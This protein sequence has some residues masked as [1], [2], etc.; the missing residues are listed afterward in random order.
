MFYVYLDALLPPLLQHTSH[1]SETHYFPL[2]PDATRPSP[3]LLHSHA[4]GPFVPRTTPSRGFKLRVYASGECF[5]SSLSLQIDWWGTLGRWG[6]RYAPA[7]ISWAVGIVALVLFDAWTE[8]DMSGMLIIRWLTPLPPSFFS[9][10]GPGSRRISYDARVDANCAR[11]SSAVFRSNILLVARRVPRV[12]LRTSSCGLLAGKRRGA[13]IRTSCTLV[14]GHR[15]WPR[16][17]RMVVDR[18]VIADIRAHLEVAR[19]EKWRE[20]SAKTCAFIAGIGVFVD[21]PAHPLASRFLGML[22]LSL[23]QLCRRSRQV[24]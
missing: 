22:D 4:S 14:A 20:G 21:F 6:T 18:G 9:P 8:F 19:S 12:V 11:C 15:D 5:P 1:P 24:P 2:A 16:M 3:I 7:A 23:L 17:D 13:L 10:S